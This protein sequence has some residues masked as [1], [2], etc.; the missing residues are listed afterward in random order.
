[1][2]IESAVAT[3]KTKMKMKKEIQEYIRNSKTLSEEKKYLYLQAVL[4]M[5]SNALQEIAHIFASEKERLENIE[6]AR[7]ISISKENQTFVQELDESIKSSLKAQMGEQE[8]QEKSHT[9]D[10]LKKLDTI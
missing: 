1:M 9:E 7:K 2:A 3:K 4:L 8:T 5:D 10:I 6:E